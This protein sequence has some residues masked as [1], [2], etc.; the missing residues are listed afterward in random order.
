MS[1][2]RR[3]ERRYTVLRNVMEQVGFRKGQKVSICRPLPHHAG[4]R[5]KTA[6]VVETYKAD[7]YSVIIQSPTGRKHRVE[8]SEI[9]KR[10]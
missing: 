10:K 2:A 1:Y 6:T 9:C 3:G 4:W 5:N 7:P 8:T